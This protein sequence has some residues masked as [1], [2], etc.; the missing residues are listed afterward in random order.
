MGSAAIF[1]PASIAR[2]RM[3]RLDR[4]RPAQTDRD[5]AGSARGMAAVSWDMIDLLFAKLSDGRLGLLVAKGGQR[6]IDVH[7]HRLQDMAV[8]VL[9]TAAV[10]EAIVLRRTWI[11]FTA[12][13]ACGID[14]RVDLRA[15][16]A[17]QAEQRLDRGTRI[18]DRFRGEIG[19][20]IAA[21]DHEDDR[22]R[23]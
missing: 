16:L 1:I 13:R 18:Y 3:M 14:D 22:V 10:H 17:R 12:R 11:G 20:A 21:Q 19:E 6:G 5:V 9:E 4:A 2:N 23:P 8:E 15:A 7:P